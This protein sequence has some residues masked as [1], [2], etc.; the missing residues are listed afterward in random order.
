MSAVWVISDTHFG[1]EKA[2]TV[3][4]RDDGSPLRPFTSAE[5]MDEELVRRWND[6]VRPGDRVYHLGDVV[7]RRQHI[8]ILGRLNGRKALV[9]GNHDIFELKLYAKYFDQIYGVK[10]FDDM[11][12]SHIPLHPESIARWG[13][14][15]HGHLHANSMNDPRYLCVSVEQTDYRPITL[16]QVRAK[17]VEM[18]DAPTAPPQ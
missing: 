14:N 15:V 4:K 9:R 11:I 6:C 12:L 17:R 3:F 18:Q 16:E 1:H 7:I 2:C 5:E 13:F 10:V 8:D